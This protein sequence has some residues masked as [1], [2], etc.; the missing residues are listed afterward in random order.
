[1][2]LHRWSQPAR[3]GV[4][5]V[6]LLLAMAPRAGAQALRAIEMSEIVRWLRAGEA[7]NVVVDRLTYRCLVQ[8]FV[9]GTE[10]TLRQAGAT[11]IVVTYVR[12]MLLCPEIGGRDQPGPTR[13]VRGATR[14]GDP[15]VDT[16]AL[17]PRRRPALD[18]AGGLAI[19]SVHAWFNP[20]NPAPRN[21]SLA[22]ALAA[23]GPAMELRAWPALSPAGGVGAGI[24]W[25][26][27]VFVGDGFSTANATLL[28]LELLGLVP[29]PRGHLLLEV[30]HQARRGSRTK[31]GGVDSLVARIDFGAWRGGVSWR[32][33]GGRDPLKGI[34]L[35]LLIEQ[36]QGGAERPGGTHLGARV[37]WV[38]GPVFVAAEYVG[39]YRAAG[40]PTQLQNIG[41]TVTA[42]DDGGGNGVLAV[43]LRR[44]WR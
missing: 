19:G 32:V 29:L 33:G 1:M 21:A 13:R 17:D 15:A 27:P 25:A 10:A 28:R 8:R 6:A 26:R 20:A 9:R 2:T 41:R 44:A 7:Q 11:D 12:Q 31:T 4:G 14:S 35:G 34:E 42:R 22:S 39:G 38:D 37:R 3:G 24:A 16:A 43:G 18:V 23:V 36:A 5:V 40:R 30:G